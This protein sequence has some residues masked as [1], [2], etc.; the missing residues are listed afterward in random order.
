[1][2]GCVSA[3]HNYFTSDQ[4]VTLLPNC[5]VTGALYRIKSGSGTDNAQI[6]DWES[7]QGRIIGK[8]VHGNCSQQ[9]ARWDCTT[10][11]KD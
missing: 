11:L 6:L 1:M 3:F 7:N 4:Q 5:S 2:N 10:P 8:R 9:T